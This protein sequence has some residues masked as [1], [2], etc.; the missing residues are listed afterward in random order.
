MLK[1]RE[2]TDLPR[3]EGW[4]RSVAYLH[5]LKAS[6]SGATSTTLLESRMM[7][8]GKS[9]LF[10]QLAL[11]SCLLAPDALAMHA[12]VQKSVPRRTVIKPRGDGRRIFAV[13]LSLDGKM[14][15]AAGATPIY[16]WELESRRKVVTLNS[17]TGAIEAIEFSPNG[18]VLAAAG[19]DGT[20]N[21]WKVPSGDQLLELAGDGFPVS[22]LTISPDGE[23]LAA[24]SQSGTV[25]IWDTANGRKLRSFRSHK[26][27]ITS[28]VFSPDGRTIASAGNYVDSK[29]R[30][31][32]AS[33]GVLLQTLPG[34]RPN[35]NSIAFSPDGNLLLSGGSDK[36]IQLWEIASG[37]QVLSLRGHT[38]DVYSVAFSL[39]GRTLISA[40]GDYTIRL[41]DAALAKEI[42][43]LKG[44]D[45]KVVSIALSSDSK[46]LA[47]GSHDGKVLLWELP[48]A[49]KRENAQIKGAK[50]NELEDL[51]SD[52]S[53]KNASK[54]YK[55]I[56]ALAQSQSEAVTLLIEK[57]KPPSPNDP[58][59]IRRLISELDGEEPAIRNKAFGELAE[60][61]LQPEPAIRKAYEETTSPELR[62]RLTALIRRLEGPVPEVPEALRRLRAIQVLE[63]I[64]TDKS[65]AILRSLGTRDALEALH[66]LKDKGERR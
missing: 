32:R 14:M 4:S 44:H 64:G 40:G 51:W 21:L 42:T 56:W 11:I 29:I 58:V 5:R 33:S 17:H 25:M 36:I 27:E 65:R 13:A 16:L 34:H 19:V 39:N 50:S 41:W 26:G 55:A 38:N 54:A 62:L 30:I 9:T 3:I 59:R 23:R 22:S 20:V 12:A 8:L 46:R 10:A 45:G 35:T 6:G 52:I 2:A 18:K 60:L 66:R 1:R 31:W 37:H 43:K 57:L 61:G 49:R 48:A 15:A 63:R 53:G 24:A 7:G 28:I 47:S